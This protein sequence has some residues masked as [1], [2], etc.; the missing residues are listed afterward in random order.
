MRG[1]LWCRRR[2]R[3]DRARWFLGRRQSLALIFDLELCEFRG[4]LRL[5]LI[6]SALELIQRF[7]YLTCDL[8][9]LLGPKDEQGQEE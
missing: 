3:G 7:P 9:Q 5:E 1:Q 8:W 4:N 2:L 6:R